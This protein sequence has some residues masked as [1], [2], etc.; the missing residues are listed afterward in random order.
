MIP[1]GKTKKRRGIRLG[2]S[3]FLPVP[4]EEP[5]DAPVRSKDVSDL[6]RRD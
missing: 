3:P 6:C 1:P 4:Y 2:A 5:I